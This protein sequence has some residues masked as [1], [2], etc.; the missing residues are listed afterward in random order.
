MENV[1]ESLVFPPSAQLAIPTAGQA[2]IEFRVLERCHRVKVLITEM[3][4]V[5]GIFGHVVL[6]R[7]FLE[8]GRGPQ[9]GS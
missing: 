2:K 9:V 1:L 7:R 6:D 8:G 4:V 5:K 3:S